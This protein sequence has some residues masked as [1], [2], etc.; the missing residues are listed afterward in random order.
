MAHRGRKV[1]AA[2]AFV[3]LALALAVVS[4][5]AASGRAREGEFS[6]AFAL[7]GTHGFKVIGLIAAKAGDVQLLLSVGRRH[8]GATYVVQGTR[9]GEEFDFELGALGKVEVEAQPTGHTETVRPKCGKPFTLEGSTFV[10]TIEFHGEEGFTEAEAQ[11]TGLRY[12]LLADEVCGLF[13]QGEDFGVGI[14]GARLRV[15]RKRGPELQINQNHPGAAVRY[16]AQITESHPGLTI[17]RSTGGHLPGGA[18]KFDPT[19]TKA[20][21]GPGAP[22]TGSATYRG[23]AP[24][25]GT[26]VAH[27]TWRGNLKVDFPGRAAVPL[28]GP[29]FKAAIIHANRTE[30]G[31]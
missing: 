20:S 21:F 31:V 18:F 25:R 26:H 16:E 7:R 14:P 1:A 2:L 6:G 23:F 11:R 27:G 29:G 10:G 4:V 24:P 28:T 30:S 9:S 22:F 15:S 5:A 13:I 8:E 3:L 19:L 17:H 12:D